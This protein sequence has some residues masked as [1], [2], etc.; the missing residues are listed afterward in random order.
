MHVRVQ[1]CSPGILPYST[2][3]I[4]SFTLIR[5]RDIAVALFYASSGP[6]SECP[7]IIAIFRK[8]P[9]ARAIAANTIHMRILSPRKQLLHH[10][11][12]SSM[13]I[14]NNFPHEPKF[15]FR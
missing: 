15:V 10:D 9:S 8:L 6:L 14:A 3:D 13:H 7:N 11:C 5:M 1:C 4:R 2:V 12:K